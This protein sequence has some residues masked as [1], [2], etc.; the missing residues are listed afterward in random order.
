MHRPAHATYRDPHRW[1]VFL[2]ISL[3]YFFVY[4]HRVSTSVIAADLLMEF[5]TTATAVEGPIY[6]EV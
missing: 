3:I 6:S 5:D 4:F 2:V 1:M